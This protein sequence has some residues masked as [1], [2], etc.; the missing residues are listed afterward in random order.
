MSHFESYEEGQ[1]SLKYFMIVTAGSRDCS[2]QVKD[3]VLANKLEV[4]DKVFV[5]LCKMKKKERLMTGKI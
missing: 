3:M 1:I 5:R 4:S 2:E